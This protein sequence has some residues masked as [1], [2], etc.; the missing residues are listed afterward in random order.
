MSRERESALYPDMKL[1]WLVLLVGCGEVTRNITDAPGGV[2]STPQELVMTS[3]ADG[4]VTVD[5]VRRPV[6]LTFSGTAPEPVA[7]VFERDSKRE[8]AGLW[9]WD[10]LEHTLTFNAGTV[11]G[12]GTRYRVEIEGFTTVQFRTRISTATSSISYDTEGAP[13]ASDSTTLD[14]EGFADVTSEFGRGSLVATNDQDFRGDGLLDRRVVR[15]ST[16]QI[17][18]WQESHVAA[19]GVTRLVSFN[20]AGPDGTWMT[21]DD[22]VASDIDV[23][24][25]N[26]DRVVRQTIRAG[27]NTI[28]GQ[29]KYEYGDHTLTATTASAA[30]ADAMW[31]TL[32][33]TISR[34]DRTSYDANGRVAE[35][36]LY[37]GTNKQ[38][39]R[40]TYEYVSNEFL[41]SK[42]VTWE[43]GP[44]NLWNTPDDRKR[45]LY[46]TSYDDQRRRTKLETHDVG[47][48]GLA[49]TTDDRL[50]E[51]VTY[52][53]AL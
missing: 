30:G 39:G 11:L 50:V 45:L 26:E 5:V 2:D 34:I 9:S 42:H 49:H 17:T 3:P 46:E 53:T 28:T 29:I 7:N 40:T 44:D 51:T 1:A 52:N 24:Y 32:D 15:D 13:M 4:E 19:P 21:S 31:G 33:D 35:V 48:D 10:S 37:D 14:A 36:R 38:L 6:V 25:D 41:E 16:D 27:T 43:A 18:L 23:S 47:A 20:G 8:V 22:R 12:Y